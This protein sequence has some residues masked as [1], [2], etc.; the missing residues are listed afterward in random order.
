MKETRVE[1]TLYRSPS[2]SSLDRV[3]PTPLEGSAAT[4]NIAMN[5]LRLDLV[6]AKDR[7]ARVQD[8]ERTSTKGR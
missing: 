2:F 3:D 4:T 7:T 8:P 6:E 1:A 5:P